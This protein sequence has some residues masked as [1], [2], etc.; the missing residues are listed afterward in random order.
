MRPLTA[1]AFALVIL[2]VIATLGVADLFEATP[3]L[4]TDRSTNS[5]NSASPFSPFAT[6]LAGDPGSPTTTSV[7][8][9]TATTLP[10]TPSTLP[11]EATTTSVPGTTTAPG[12]SSTSS[13]PAPSTTASTLPA[14]SATTVPAEA[15]GHGQPGD[16]GDGAT[17]PEPDTGGR[18]PQTEFDPPGA[19]LSGNRPPVS[20]SGQLP[21]VRRSNIPPSS[22]ALAASVLVAL[23][24]GAWLV[25]RKRHDGADEELLLQPVSSEESPTAVLDEAK[26]VLETDEDDPTLAGGPAAAGDVQTLNLLFGLGQALLDADTAVPQVENTLETVAERFGITGLGAVILP[27]SLVLSIHHGEDVRTAAGT[28]GTQQ[29]RLDQVDD[30][31]RLSRGLIRGQMS[32]A[33]AQAELS[34]IRTSE[35]PFAPKT[36]VSGHVLAAA[37]IVMILG[38]TWREVILGGLLG[39]V[40]GTL[41]VATR[42]V[43]NI[44]YAPFQPLIAAS[45]ASIIVFAMTRV[46]DG[47]IVFPLLVA[48]IVT[49]LPGGR[50][51]MGVLELVTGHIVT[52]TSRVMSGVMQLVLLAI[53]L[54]AGSQLIG[55]GEGVRE[56]TA[57]GLLAAIAPWFAVALFGV[58]VS[59]VYGAIRSSLRWILMVLYV[60]YAGQV[61]GALFFG[62]ALSGFFGAL[63]M[64][65]IAILVARQPDGPSPLVTFMPAFWLLVPGALGL[66]GV[67]MWLDNPA[68]AGGETLFVALT[69]MIGISLGI[70]LGLTLV[71]R[72]RSKW[73]IGDVGVAEARLAE[74]VE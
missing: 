35:P 8:D 68:G 5:T 6:G 55:A 38:G 37:S 61:I 66:R 48:P 10:E 31:T 59:W 23:G 22:I 7:P 50:L 34:R 47:L 32:V 4:A 13:V 20:G 41:L 52:G 39:G 46:M 14:P 36:M 62:P 71:Q 53:G 3:A 44:A 58:G 15:P 24:V 25:T 74:A 29:L 56:S 2:G 64:T 33:E 43:N 45:V 17:T 40:V 16:G 60:A 11:G 73:W 30:L 63:A 65:P 69:I 9:G 51:S 49:L 26:P 28:T 12:T 67:S 72:N 21:N 1:T 70:L 27:N 19:D 18:P 42:R 54:S 57:S